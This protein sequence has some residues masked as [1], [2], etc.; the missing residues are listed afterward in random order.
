[1]RNS[2]VSGIACAGVRLRPAAHAQP[3]YAAG[4]GVEHLKFDAQ[5]VGNDF[6]PLWNAARKA[7]YQ[8][9]QRVYLFLR[10]LRAQAGVLMLLEELD[11]GPRVSDQAAVA[12]FDQARTTG[13]V[14]LVFDLSDN[15]LDHILDRDQ[16][17]YSAEFVDDHR[18]VSSCL[19]HL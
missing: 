9:A 1:M 5:W 6:A 3:F 13:L 17:V 12:A 16:S 2:D 8:P 15:L 4:I 14:V 18:D 11:R 19:A 10:A 7:R